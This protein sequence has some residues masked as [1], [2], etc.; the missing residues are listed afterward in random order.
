MSGE[1]LTK[2]LAVH[3]ALQLGGVGNAIVVRVERGGVCGFDARDVGEAFWI[4]DE[5]TGCR[6]HVCWRHF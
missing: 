6:R 5:V 4:F 1:P 2:I 3:E